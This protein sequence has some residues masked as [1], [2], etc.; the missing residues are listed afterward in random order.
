MIN[1]NLVILFVVE[2]QLI[3]KNLLRNVEDQHFYVYVKPVKSVNRVPADT[4]SKIF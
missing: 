4:R 3:I 2:F 1:S